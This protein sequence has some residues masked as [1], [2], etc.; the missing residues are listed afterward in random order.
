MGGDRAAGVDLG[1]Y[2][3]STLIQSALRHSSPAWWEWLEGSLMHCDISGFTAMSESLAAKGREGAE[4]MVGV[5]NSFFEP[6]L[7]TVADYGG[8]QMKFGG[9]AMLLYFGGDQHADRAAAC[10]LAMQNAMQPFRRV[11]AGGQEHALRMRA[12]IH[13]GRFFAA[14]VGQPQKLMHYVVTG[15]DVSQAA[16][17]EEHA[18]LGRVYVSSDAARA[19]SERARTAPKE[20]GL[21]VVTAADAPRDEQQRELH[22]DPVA[23]RYLGA[24]VRDGMTTGAEEHRRVTV[25]FINLLGLHELLEQ[26][27]EERTFGALS[28]FVSL[29]VDGLERHGGYLLGS[30]VAGEGDKFIGL[31][32]APVATVRQEAAAMNFALELR[33]DVKEAGLP[34]WLRTGMNTAYVFAGEVGSRRRR[35]YTVIGDGVNLAARLMA[36]A[37]AGDILVSRATAE[38]APGFALQKLR[39]LQVKGKKEPAQ[40]R[41]LTGLVAGTDVRAATPLVGRQ[42]EMARLMQAAAAAANGRAST[43]RV[44]GEP[45]IGKTRLV[46]EFRARL[47]RRGW[48]TLTTACQV[49]ARGTPFGPWRALLMEDRVRQVARDEAARLLDQIERR[50]GEDDDPRARR[51]AIVAGITDVVRKAAEDSL[52]LLVVEDVHWADES[53]LAVLNRLPTVDPGRLLTCVT[54]LHAPPDG[55]AETDLHLGELSADAARRL[56]SASVG[57][58]AD[59]DTVIERARGNPLFLT[60]FLR[61]GAQLGK[62]PDSLND[63]M[64]ARIDALSPE[65]RQVLRAAAVAGSRFEAKFVDAIASDLP[66]GTAGAVLPL[67]AERGF[68]REEGEAGV[69][70]FSHALLSEVA[71][72]SAPFAWRRRMH[73]KAGVLLEE[74]YRGAEEA[75]AEILL[76]HSERAGDDRK[77]VRYAAAAGERSARVFANRDAAAYFERGLAALG[78]LGTGQ[79]D[80]GLLLERMGDMLELTGRHREAAETFQRS[81]STFEGSRR[82]RP[83]FLPRGFPARTREAALCRK[84]AVATEHASEYDEALG[85]LDRAR[86]AL[87]GRAARL[88]GQIYATTCGVLFR[89]GEYTDALRWG[90]QAVRTAQAASDLRQVAYAQNMM[91]TAL[92]EAGRLRQA[93]RYLRPAV[94]EYHELGDYAGQGSANNNLGSAYQLLGMY[95]AALYHYGIALIADERSGDMIDAAIV[96]NNMAETL[97]LLDREDEALER[98]GAVL[99][100]AASQPDLADLRGW[101]EITTARCLRATGRT[102]EAARHLAAGVR[103]LRDVGSRGLLTEAMVD[104]AEQALAEGSAAL[105]RRRGMAALKQARSIDSRLA[106]A[107][108][109]RVLGECEL[110][111]GRTRESMRLL[112]AALDG[113]RRVAAEYEEAQTAVVLA[114]SHLADGHRGSARR[115][116]RR[117]YRVFSRCGASRRA[118]NAAALLEAAA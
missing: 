112:Q 36:A 25:V 74:E 93:V 20:G 13:S 61:S 17:V 14:S 40:V 3:P 111:R 103:T 53:S 55:S 18:R 104:R 49:H 86:S 110:H 97:M 19:L 39:P 57:K 11:R 62:V 22:A 105:A 46:A 71:Y 24:A 113:C 81:L 41:R 99:R 27:S 10:G 6:M 23:S 94:K 35:E 52:T 114:E 26:A 42:R 5:L 4:L 108:A 37:G 16:I 44:R 101:A 67:L 51:E 82:S 8:V 89:K 79:A 77:A 50:A 56:V 65:E 70:T 9:D 1:P 30:D 33:R 7:E 88:R 96:H 59:V 84:I 48:A 95:D 43:I 87:P 12:G 58:P 63:L 106:E 60:E 90:R 32:G 85:W 91:A 116:L 31:F 64:T 109:E 92:I 80:R 21:Y 15:R 69:Y 102:E 78:R 38:A 107:R 98:L 118:A 68:T 66:A 100:I 47:A 54:S 117:A 83:T 45:G 2:L 73:A 29:L 76:H 75:V 28:A 72:E 115:L 34:L